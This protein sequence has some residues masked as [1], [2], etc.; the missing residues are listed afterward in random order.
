MAPS[1]RKRNAYAAEAALGAGAA[2][3]IGS[4]RVPEMTNA[5]V[6]NRRKAIA[7]E[8]KHESKKY[9]I[10]AEGKKV[11]LKKLP[12]ST[13]GGEAVPVL[14]AEGKPKTRINNKT[15]VEETIYTKTKPTRPREQAARRYAEEKLIPAKQNVHNKA[16]LPFP[17]SNWTYEPAGTPKPPKYK[18]GK[19]AR[20]EAGRHAKPEKPTGARKI[21][22]KLKEVV[23]PGPEISDSGTQ[24]RQ[25]WMY[26]EKGVRVPTPAHLGQLRR[27]RVMRIGLPVAA[28][29][30]T[31]GAWNSMKQQRLLD[32]KKKVSKAD[33]R[34]AV[35]GTIGGSAGLL[36]YQTPSYIEYR[37]RGDA[38]KKANKSPKAQ[39]A[40][41][42]WKKKYKIEA[43]TPR[44]IPTWDEAYRHYPR[45]MPDWKARRAW[46]YTHTGGSGRA[47]FAASTALGAGAAIAADRKLLRPRRGKR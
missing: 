43:G 21:A 32:Q 7:R 27:A 23:A 13:P 38:D 17:T 26:N 28:A 1:E 47:A 22:L 35:A 14:D 31:H 12:E 20:A 5:L 4:N 6:I 41:A 42:R 29:V 2:G 33:E 24:Q 34:D 15:G 39:E 16:N 30:A 36:A 25:R 19:H 10:D 9:G 11:R 3:V 40:L 45:A 37:N 46:A 8:I 44:G 18:P